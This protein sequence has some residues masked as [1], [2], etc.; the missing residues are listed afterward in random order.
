MRDS[1]SLHRALHRANAITHQDANSKWPVGILGNG[2]GVKI[3]G[4]IEL[5]PTL[6]PRRGGGADAAACV[7][8]LFAALGCTVNELLLA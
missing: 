8:G 7:C 2:A 1:P 4:P 5:L 3:Y 6:A